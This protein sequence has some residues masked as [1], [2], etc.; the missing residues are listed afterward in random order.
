L[1]KEII[2]LWKKK[3][4]PYFNKESHNI[5]ISII[6]ILLSI[7]IAVLLFPWVPPL[8]EYHVGDIAKRDIKSPREFLIEDTIST[9]KNRINARNRVLDLYDLDFDVMHSIE[10]NLSNT[11]KR[12]RDSEDLDKKDFENTLNIKL[13]SREFAILKKNKFNK[14]IE[15]NIIKLIRSV[16][17][18]GIVA[19]KESILRE[20]RKGI[21]IRTLPFKKEYIL[22]D[23]PSIYELREAREYLRRVSIED[24]DAP[25][26]RVIISISQKL[27]RPNLTFNRAETKE[28]KLLAEKSVKPVFY[29]IKKGEMIVR[30]GERIKKEQMA[31]LKLLNQINRGTSKK[32]ML[33]GIFLMNLIII[34]ILY[35]FGVKNIR[36]FKLNNKDIFLITG[37]LFTTIIIIKIFMFIAKALETNFSLL[38][39]SS[40][41][42]IIPVFV[43]SMLVR[44]LL[45]SE[46]AIIFSVFISIISAFLL[47]KNLFLLI[48]FLVGSVVGAHDVAQCKERKG[49]IKA[50]FKVGLINSFLIISFDIINGSFI[51]LSLINITLEIILGFIGGIGGSIIVL[52]ITPIIEDLFDYTTDIKLLELSNLEHPLLKELVVKAQGSYLHSITVGTLGETAAKSINANPLLVRVGA[53]YHDIG[54]IKKPQYF[55]ENQ[56]GGDNRHEKL[57]PYMSSLILISHVKEGVE[58]AKKY[59]L[60]GKIIDM[61]KQHHGTSL[62]SYFYQKA[63]EQENPGIQAINEM[64]FRYPGPKPQTRESGIVMLADAVEAASKTLT[65]YSPSR[66]QGMVQ[67]IINKIFSDGQL[68]ECELTLKDLNKIAKSF[69]IILGGIYH[70]RIDYPEPAYK[71]NDENIDS[72]QTPKDKVKK[73][74]NKKDSKENLKRLGMS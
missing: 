63:K 9:E 62:I 23:V 27:I 22:K 40:Y 28:R 15:D 74:G 19:N 26:R 5:F 3:I 6:G 47:D 32:S 68:E 12:F 57:S 69:N 11:F 24:Y 37:I 36:K 31:K 53:Y 45:N 35:R 67:K 18:K 54:K 64:D 20:K 10:K 2:E 44:L 21:L 14:D 52:G 39:S 65:D 13:S 43:G 66:I 33:F 46:I 55:I 25:T 17:E 49:L 38:P 70:H 4:I 58:L 59:R 29:Q 1:K 71:K 16:M 50:G 8:V 34:T 73:L 48:Y 51:N 42:L 30:E 7:I 41:Y 56:S 61:I 60:G 72:K